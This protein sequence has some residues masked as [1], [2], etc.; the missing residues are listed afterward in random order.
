MFVRLNAGLIHLPSR[1]QKRTLEAMAWTK[2]TSSNY[3]LLRTDG[4][5]L[6]IRTVRN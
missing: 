5:C 6:V 4:V 1:C 2:G 3:L